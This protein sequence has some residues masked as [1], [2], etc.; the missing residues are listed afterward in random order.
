MARGEMSFKKESFEP[1]WALREQSCLLLISACQ[2]G[3]LFTDIQN[4]S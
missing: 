2:D 4:D 3:E 1:P